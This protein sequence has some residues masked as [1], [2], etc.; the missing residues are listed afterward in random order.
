MPCH[1]PKVYVTV[2]HVETEE[3]VRRLGPYANAADAR[4]AMPAITGQAMTWKRTAETWRAEKYPLAYHVPADA[5][6]PVDRV[7]Q[8]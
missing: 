3:V 4:R 1:T 5:P 2:S 6:D 7:D 8:G